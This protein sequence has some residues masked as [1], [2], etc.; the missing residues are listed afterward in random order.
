[1]FLALA[2]IYERDENLESAIQLFEKAL[3]NSNYRESK[4]IWTA[5]HRLLI[6]SN[7]PSAKQQLNRAIQSLE[8]HK[9]LEV[10]L[11]FAISEFEVGSPERARILFEELLASSPRKTDIWNIY[12][13]KEVKLGNL[14]GARNLFQRMVTQNVGSKF[15]KAAFKKYLAF[16]TQYG[17]METQLQVKELAKSF[18]AKL[19]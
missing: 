14:S 9:H 16:E 5:Y 17:N 12:V 7:D 19:N 3:K 10:I 4:K 11:R 1:L 8:P 18:V 6:Q 13:D 15:M 2:K